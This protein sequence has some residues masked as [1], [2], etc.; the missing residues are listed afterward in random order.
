L[1]SLRPSDFTPDRSGSSEL[2]KQAEYPITSSEKQVQKKI[3]SLFMREI[4][5]NFPE[6]ARN[7][8]QNISGMWIPGMSGWLCPSL[9][10]DCKQ[11]FSGEEKRIIRKGYLAEFHKL[12]K[13]PVLRPMKTVKDL[14][15]NRLVKFNI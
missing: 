12:V 2:T 4:I 10:Q 1:D 3:R 8:H 7:F 15:S 9:M 11:E 13:P 5:G 14:S 6:R